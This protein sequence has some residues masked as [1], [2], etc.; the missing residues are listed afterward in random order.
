MRRSSALPR[1][2]LALVLLCTAPLPQAALPLA[3][4][5][6]PLPSLAPML[7]RVL[8]AVVNISTVTAIETADHPLLRDP[9]FRRFFDLPRERKRENS[10]L[11]SGVIVDARRG[12]VLTNHHVIDKADQIRVTLQDGRALEASLIGTDP[13]TDIAVLEIPAAGLSALP[14]A[15]A[16]TLAVGDFVV[17]IGNPFGL[18]QTVTSG[19]VS[20]LGR[21]GLGI[22]G[23]ENFIQTD[24]SINPGNSGGPLVNLRGELIGINTAI[25]A[26][27]GGNIGIGFAIPVDMARAIMTQ[28]VE[29]GEMRRG[30]FGAAVQN[31]D[32]ALAAALGLEHRAGAVVT[33]ID[34]DSAAAAAGLRVGDVILGVN[35]EPIANAS[36]VRNRFGVLRVGSRVALDI[37]RDGRALRLN[38]LIADPY[39]DYLPGARIDEALAGALIGAFDRSG[40]VPGLPVGR[41]EPDSPAWAAGLREGDRILNANGVRID[42][43]QTLARVLRR[44]GGLYS[45]SLQR[46]DEL[47]RLSR[48]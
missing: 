7:E 45:L 11:G 3:V 22:E 16:D 43:L 37:V 9:F 42:A 39:R 4:D 32:H 18:R 36:D 23:Y 27:G 5:G 1:L 6:Q 15:A 33:R 44:A 47:V 30:Q 31:I 10:S 34:P 38:G 19:I 46:G 48:R 40:G 14:F 21:S 26:P 8:P 41:V 20:G 13:E 24:A 2:A 28:L 17:A 25:L 29:H 35:D 12:L